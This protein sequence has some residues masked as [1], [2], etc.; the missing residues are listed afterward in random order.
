MY[1]LETTHEIRE[2]IDVTKSDSGVSGPKL[3]L[4][5]R[6]L[7][8]LLAEHLPFDPKETTV[9][10]I[11]RSGIF[12]AEGIYCRMGCRFDVYDP[13]HETFVRPETKY[14]L[15]AD[16]VIH[17]GKTIRKILQPDMFV[18]SC[19]TQADAAAEFDHQLYTVRISHNA[20]TGSDIRVQQG[21]RG[22]DTTLRLFNRI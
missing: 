16:A 11:L 18:A 21:D 9:V 12:F 2:L 10:A 1:V 8:E 20:F 6:R 19:V 14:V 3:V 17:T 5:H 4:A 7:G 15:L 13:K 22:P